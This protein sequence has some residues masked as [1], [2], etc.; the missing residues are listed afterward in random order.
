MSTP[1]RVQPGGVFR[2]LAAHAWLKEQKTPQL[3]LVWSK[4]GPCTDPIP[5]S[6]PWDCL[7]LI[8]KLGYHHID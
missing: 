2:L 3:F 5:L 6:T 4:K 1:T 7:R 8:C